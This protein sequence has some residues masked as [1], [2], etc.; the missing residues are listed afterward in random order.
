MTMA[1]N[2]GPLNIKH[3]P[4]RARPK[5]ADIQIRPYKQRWKLTRKNYRLVKDIFSFY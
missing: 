2:F 1:R 3:L 5:N 4:V